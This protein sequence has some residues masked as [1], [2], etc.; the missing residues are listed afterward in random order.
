MARRESWNPVPLPGQYPHVFRPTWR[1]G[2]TAA[3]GLAVA[4]GCAVLR[5]R[6]VVAFGPSD[7]DDAYMFLRYARHLL[8]GQGLVWNPGGPP[9]FGVTSPAYLLLV[10]GLRALVPRLDD[11]RLLQLASCAM[12]LA[13]AALMTF[14]CARFARHRWLRRN[15]GLW[16]AVLFP[17]VTLTEPFEFHVRTGMDTTLS[18]L[19]NTAVLWAGLRLSEHP[20]RRRAVVSALVSFAAVAVRPDNALVAAGVPLLLLGARW[21]VA[22]TFVAVLGGLLVVSLALARAKLGTALP[23]AFHAKLPGVYG[24]FA[25]EYGWNPYLLLEVFLRAALPFVAVLVGLIDRRH[26]RAPVALLLPVLPTFAVFFAMNQIM[27]HLGRFYFP[28]LPCFVVAAALVVDRASTV[29]VSRLVLTALALIAAFPLLRAAGRRYDARAQTQTLADLGG[30]HTPVSLPGIDSW[31]ASIEMARL[32]AAAPGA[33]F[34]MSEHGYV[35][36]RAPDTIIVDMLGL[37]DR[38]FARFTTAEL[39]RRRPALVWMPHPDHTQM[40]RDLLDSAELWRDYDYYPDA[41]TYGVAVRKDDER[42]RA[43]F[44]ERWNAV[45]A[46][47]PL[48]DYKARRDAAKP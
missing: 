13:A 10:T 44:V 48:D 29:Q 43:L 19:A 24:G 28:F 30:Y 31:R 1:E 9:V 4:L 46:T 21:V 40:I 2:L 3:L 5:V 26:W 39:W 34:A 35:G 12:G 45:Y 20:G 11:G 14:T 16:A 25:G 15:W 37:H 33:T 18:L 7:F 41:F 22:R 36:A 38:A 6:G 27:G 32:A 47:R 8:A 23:L 17:L 42:V